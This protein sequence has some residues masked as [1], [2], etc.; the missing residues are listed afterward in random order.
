MPSMTERSSELTALSILAAAAATSDEMSCTAAVLPS[1]IVMMHE[2]PESFF[3]HAKTS[4]GNFFC[5]RQP[6][7]KGT[8]YC[9]QHFCQIEAKKGSDDEEESSK[10]AY[11]VGQDKRC[12]GDDNEVRCFATS[13]RGRTCAY[14]AVNYTKYCYLHA[15]YDTNPPPRRTSKLLSYD[16][17][18]R[19]CRR[20]TTAKLA[21]KHAAA[22][23]PIPPTPPVR[24]TRSGRRVKP[25]QRYIVSPSPTDRFKSS[26]EEP[27][28]PKPNASMSDLVHTPIFKP[29]GG[30]A[31]N[32]VMPFGN[33]GRPM[34]M[35]SSSDGLDL[36]LPEDNSKSTVPSFVRDCARS[37]R[38]SWSR[39]MTNIRTPCFYINLH[40]GDQQLL[41]YIYLQPC[42]IR[43]YADA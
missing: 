3:C 8:N 36:R 11:T 43:V 16:S 39:P 42:L 12:T 21:D 9:K 10:A 32:K 30:Q 41:E 24:M 22:M 15:D 38:L 19:P 28:T 6:C 34:S 13:T 26:D 35:Q 27:D 2:Q 20:R 23:A 5:K 31:P 37:V 18:S 40:I 29:N 7:Y 14:I 17:L 33:V 25:R 4:R 1:S